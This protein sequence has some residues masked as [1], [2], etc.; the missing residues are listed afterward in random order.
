M[1]QQPF[2]SEL[3][4]AADFVRRCLNLINHE[5]VTG[6]DDRET[7]A[8]VGPC[9]FQLRT[10]RGRVLVVAVDWDGDAG[11]GPGPAGSDRRRLVDRYVALRTGRTLDD[12]RDC[13]SVATEVAGLV[14]A[15][16]ASL[17]DAELAAEIEA[18]G[19]AASAGRKTAE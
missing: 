1:R 10:N 6:Y 16:A 7:A 19:D 9:A 12:A 5:D 13:T 11:L 3:T 15:V 2:D 18:W 8:V 17:T 14:G 4:P